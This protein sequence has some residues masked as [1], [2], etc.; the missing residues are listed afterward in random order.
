MVTRVDEPALY[1]KSVVIL[2][3]CSQTTGII[4]NSTADQVMAESNF[5]ALRK[6][7]TTKFDEAVEKKIKASSSKLESDSKKSAEQSERLKSLQSALSYSTVKKTK[8]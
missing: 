3:A 2:D 6:E 4:D 8:R 7:K 5:A 1:G